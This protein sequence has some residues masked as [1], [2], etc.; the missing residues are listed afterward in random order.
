MN[1]KEFC[2]YLQGFL[3][4]RKELNKEQINTI[5]YSLDKVAPINNQFFPKIYLGSGVYNDS[6]NS[7]YANISGFCTGRLLV[8]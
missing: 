3:S 6:Y 2:Y 4:E 1:E 8:V 7:R 5:I